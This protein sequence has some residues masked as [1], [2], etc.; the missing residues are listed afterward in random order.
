ME[1]FSVDHSGLVLLDR[2]GIRG[3][4]VAE[5]PRLGARGVMLRLDARAERELFVQRTPILVADVAKAGA[6]LGS[7]AKVLTRLKIRS[8]LVVPVVIANRVIGSFSL[9]VQSSRGAGKPRRFSKRDVERC[10]ALARQVAEAIDHANRSVGLSAVRRLALRLTSAQHSKHSLL[11]AIVKAAVTLLNAHSGGVYEFSEHA[12]T[13]TLVAAFNAT[14]DVRG[15]TL[16]AG[17]GLAGRLLLSKRAWARVANY[18][19]YKW[20]AKAFAESRPFFAVLEVK[21]FWQDRVIGVLYVNDKQGRLFDLQDVRLLQLFAAHASLAIGEANRRERDDAMME[22]L[23]LLPLAVREML[24]ELENRTIDGLYSLIARHTATLLHAETAAVFLTNGPASLSLVG[25]H[26]HRD[27]GFDYGRPFPIG[28]NVGSLT[29]YAA[30]TNELLNLSGDALAR[31]SARGKEP[32]GHMESGDCRSFISIPLYHASDGS[33]LGLLKAENRRNEHRVVDEHSRFSSEDELVMRLLGPVVSA[34]IDD[35]QRLEAA[36]DDAAMLFDREAH[37]PLLASTLHQMFHLSGVVELTLNDFCVWAESISRI[38][39]GRR[40]E[41][42]QLKE[43]AADMIAT[44]D[45]FLTMVKERQAHRP[46]IA[47]VNDAIRSALRLSRSSLDKHEVVSD[48]YLQDGLPDVVGDK[49][50]LVELFA[51]LIRNAERAMVSSRRRV[52]TLRS[53]LSPDKKWVEVAVEDTGQG[54]GNEIASRIFSA[55]FTTR[56]GMGG[57]GFGLAAAQELLETRY[58]GR[59]FLVNHPVGKGTAFLLRLRLHK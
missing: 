52:L 7:V 20:R 44:T 57:H 11:E 56:P 10:G 17:E 26:G 15:Q 8:I 1:L 3:R 25:S 58:G 51:N 2:D 48:L 38:P 53:R 45:E 18:T 50:D 42:Q 23:R 24:Q 12:S 47:A 46:G 36:R 29:G 6:R 54:I 37:G 30:A 14:R 41:L 33:I 21:L 39:P 34:A 19:R 22:R 59:L 13:L 16:R 35:A 49:L 32:P 31:H 43:R 27:G 5:H 9:D 28:D 4:V 55:G 40:K